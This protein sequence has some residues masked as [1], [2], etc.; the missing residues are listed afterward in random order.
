MYEVSA[1]VFLCPFTVVLH[2]K[3]I[4]RL[5]FTTMRQHNMVTTH[6][7]NAALMHASRTAETAG[8]TEKIIPAV[9]AY[10]IPQNV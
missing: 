4:V 10:F 5:H 2:C 6:W 1:V 9:W 7:Y 3:G 8:F